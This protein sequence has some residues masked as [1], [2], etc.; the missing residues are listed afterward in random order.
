MYLRWIQIKQ[1]NSLQ[2][3][4]MGCVRSCLLTCTNTHVYLTQVS[5]ESLRGV[6]GLASYMAEQ[7]MLADPAHQLS[8]GGRLN[9]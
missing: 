1:N 7:R 9:I 4:C 3:E 8:R 2:T 6:E 5:R